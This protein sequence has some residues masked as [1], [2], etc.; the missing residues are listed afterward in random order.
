MPAYPAISALLVWAALTSGAAQAADSDPALAILDGRALFEKLWVAAP[1]STRASD[2]LGPYYNARACSACH[3]GAGRGHPPAPGEAPVSF[4]VMTARPDGAGGATPDPTYGHQIQTFAAPGLLAE[5]QVAVDWTET[6]VRL[7]DGSEVAL[8]R[9]EVAVEALAHGPLDPATL[10]SPR[11]APPVRGLGLIEAIPA[12]A[13]LTRADPD[14][15]D[16]DG[17]SGRAN[18]L[19]DDAGATLGRFGWKAATPDLPA[20]TARAFAIDIGLSNPALPEPWGDCT[21]TQDDCRTAPHG[22]GD[23][24]GFEIDQ[25]ALDAVATFLR[26]IEAPAPRPSDGDDTSPGEALFHGAGCA[27]CHTPSYATVG[28]GEIH[29]Y[30]DLLLHDMGPG[31]ADGIVEA[32]ASGSEWRTAPL[33]GIGLTDAGGGE[34][35]YLHDGRARN[36]LEAILW[37]G[38]EADAARNSV[39]A[40]PEPDRA[41]LIRFLE[42]L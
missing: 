21:E 39:M 40:M 32:G 26:H 22:D 13:I 18:L 12:A 11:V 14:D 33:W 9:P 19:P 6:R 2:G 29:P 25:K 17:I 15:A 8:R 23:A 34:T 27:S 20:S 5:G 7:D 30:S 10:L 38:G 37:H 4:V 41:A 1:S 42:S 3:Q 35:S 16:G 24:R 28:G 31:I 36:L